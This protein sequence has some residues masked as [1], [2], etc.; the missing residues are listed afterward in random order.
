MPPSRL[1]SPDLRD[2]G[3]PPTL[4]QQVI[5]Q[6][7]LFFS[8][9]AHPPAARLA[10]EMKNAN[11][12]LG[13]SR[14]GN[15]IT[16]GRP[17][18]REQLDLSTPH[19][20]PG[21]ADPLWFNMRAPNQWPDPTYLP[22]F[23]R[24]YEE[25]IARMSEISMQFT[26]LIAEAIGLSAH[27]LD[28]FFDPDQ[29]HKLKLVKYPEDPDGGAGGQGVGPHKDSMLSSYLLQ[30]SA[31]RGLQ[32]QNLRGEWIDCPPKEGT[33]VVAIGQGLEA[34]TGGVCAST[35]HRVL[36]PGAASGP[37]YSIPFFQ[38]VSYNAQFESMDVPEAVKKMKEEMIEAQ[39]GKRLDDI[40]FTFVKGKWRSLGEATLMNRVKSHV[41]VSERWVSL[42]PLFLCSLL[43]VMDRP[44]NDPVLGGTNN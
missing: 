24:V 30:A 7:Y 3:I 10:I 42:F 44:K 22:D 39:G 31:H 9:E 4:I 14:L 36:S 29:Q 11:S 28:R 21:P 19:P 13:Y 38:G 20:L 41:D 15:E 12:F 43:V 18:H 35:T 17:D 25:Y 27:A 1:T 34:I 16:A 37:R 32:A 33:V 40:E 23:R 6:C 2:T 26:V 5:E 8:D